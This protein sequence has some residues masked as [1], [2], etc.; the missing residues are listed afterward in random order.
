MTAQPSRRA[1]LQGGAAV[2]VLGSGGT[3]L[4][5]TATPTAKG[6]ATP[7]PLPLDP[8]PAVHAARRL[9]FGPTP[10]LVAHIREVGVPAFVDEQLDPASIDDGQLELLLRED[11][12][13]EPLG[14]VTSS[15]NGMRTVAELQRETL[16]RQTLTNRQL[17]E[18]VCSFWSTHLSIYAGHTVA[19]PYLWA[20]DRD[21]VRAHALGR[22]SDLLL[23]SAK[24]PA[25]LI[26]LD[27]WLS[28]A[29]NINENYGRE[30]LELHSV[31][32]HGGY[33]ETDIRQ[34][35]LALTGWTVDRRR[36]TFVY[37]PAMRHVGPLKVMGWEHPNADAAGGLA[38]GESLI[39]YLAHHP[40]T[41]RHLA[42]KLVRRFVADVPPAA[43]V[44]SA[45]KVYLASDTQVEPVVRHILSSAAFRDAYGAKYLRPQEYVLG[46]LRVLG[47]APKR[48]DGFLSPGQRLMARLTEMGH[49]PFGWPPPDGFPDTAAEWQSTAATLS[50]WNYA[51]ALV[52]NQVEGFAPDFAALVGTPLPATAGELVDRL[53]LRVCF[54][55]VGGTHRSAL[56]R[57][58]GLAAGAP[59]TQQ[60]ITA[61]VRQLVALLLSSPYAQYR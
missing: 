32:V 10:G 29:K 30:I 24:S 43:L 6:G 16:L 39:S 14:V 7:L 51:Q 44:A 4:A 57:Y 45:A 3:A 28:D 52:A 12:G 58:V 37:R 59:V 56:L 48:Q 61:H 40:S 38:V 20:H 54:Q 31:G 13:S 53:A 42:T 33:T 17:L 55:R 5:Q 8:D 27:N 46:S 34:V 22:F 15:V 50:R 19:A 49:A 2:A 25:M 9:T 23:G 36:G 60:V 1:V 47:Y 26:Y 41:A 11:L 18:V 21:V 35:A